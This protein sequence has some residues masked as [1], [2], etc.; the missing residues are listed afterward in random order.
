MLMLI[1]ICT[2]IF[3]WKELEP[4]WLGAWSHLPPNHLIWLHFLS[5]DSEL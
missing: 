5:S 2:K 3:I 4:E 1:K